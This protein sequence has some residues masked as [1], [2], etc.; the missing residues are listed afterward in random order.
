[1]EQ[2]K[3]ITVSESA[4]QRLI[5]G[6]QKASELHRQA[7]NKAYYNQA[8]DHAIGIVKAEYSTIKAIG[9]ANTYH[10]ILNKIVISLTNLKQ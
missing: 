5:E 1:M 7:S 4:L 6:N 8:I 10:N 9:E 2:D 3:G